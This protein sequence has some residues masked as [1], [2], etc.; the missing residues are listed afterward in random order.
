MHLIS[1]YR[2]RISKLALGGVSALA[3]WSVLPAQ[4]QAA[5]PTFQNSCRNIELLVDPS[6]VRLQAECRT[7]DGGYNRTSFRLLG[8]S[9]EHGTLRRLDSEP[10][11][12]QKSCDDILLHT[13]AEEV[14]VTAVCE[15]G[16]GGTKRTSILVYNVDN[17]DGKLTA[18]RN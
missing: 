12:F 3:L 10:S 18:R 11:S 14:K 13:S 16:R 6:W 5:P 17:I 7:R 15:D 9:N 1:F 8:I 2:K 4:A